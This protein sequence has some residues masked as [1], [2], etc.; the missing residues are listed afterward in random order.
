MNDNKSRD[1]FYGVIAIATL[2]VALIGATLAYFSVS[3]SSNEGAVNARA[4]IVSI[5]YKDGQEVLAQASQLI[6]ATFNVVSTVYE[7]NS[8][9]ISAD[10]NDTE[11]DLA[12]KS[13]LCVDDNNREVCSIYRFSVGSDITRRITATLNTEGNGFQYLAYA[14]RNVNTGT[15]L[16]LR[17]DDEGGHQYIGLRSCDNTTEDNKCFTTENDIKTYM[18]NAQNSILGYD[19]DNAFNIGEVTGGLDNPQVYDLVLFI[20]ENNA[21]QNIDQGKEYR[22][23]INI[24]IMDEG[25]GGKLTGVAE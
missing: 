2:I 14:V 12:S 17:E 13:N 18:A 25:E 21:N 20:N 15:W 8:E 7:R 9:D 16:D 11:N 22:G 3:I 19:S 23:T 6:P 24:Q 5:E 4:A 1:I 10:Y